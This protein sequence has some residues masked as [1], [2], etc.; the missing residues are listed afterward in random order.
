MITLVENIYQLRQ[1]L[2]DFVI[3]KVTEKGNLG[4]L[5]RVEI[6]D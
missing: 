6:Q 4:I 1:G 3:L 2:Q 5:P